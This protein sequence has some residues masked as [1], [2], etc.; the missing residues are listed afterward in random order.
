MAKH[1][2]GGLDNIRLKFVGAL[3]KFDNLDDFDSPFEFQSKMNADEENPF[4]PPNLPDANEAFGSAMNS[5]DDDLEDDNDV[6]F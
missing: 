4:A 3:G 2:N 5:D 1:R 6:P